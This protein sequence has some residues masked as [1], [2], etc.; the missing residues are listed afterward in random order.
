M[1][2]VLF[3]ILLIVN[4]VFFTAVQMGWSILEQPVAAQPALNEDKMRLLSPEQ[5]SLIEGK[6]VNGETTAIL[7]SATCLEWGEFLDADLT[8]ATDSLSTLGLAK[9]AIKRELEYEIAY[10]I[11]IPP[12]KDKA[13]TS[14][15][16]AQLKELNISEYFIVQEAGV[17]QNAISLGVF[18][19]QD[20][21]EK[22][23][24]FLKSKGVRSA[25][26]GERGS[27]LKVSILRFNDVDAATEAQL[28]ELQRTFTGSE[29]KNVQCGL[30]R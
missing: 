20:A 12:L 22:Y 21:A 17:W 23:L 29:L 3:W 10:W 8:L 27:K 13:A 26:M 14:K 25:Q 24:R 5:I 7:D 30:T 6:A 2:R 16:I 28:T 15:K 19:T 18:K 1:I 9:N 4:I 11:F